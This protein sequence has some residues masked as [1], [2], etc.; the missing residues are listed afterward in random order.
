MCKWK[1]QNVSL[2]LLGVP[3]T[4]TLHDSLLL[5]LKLKLKHNI[6]QDCLTKFL[7]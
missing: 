1:N 7:K 5:L 3:V 2:R 4:V 6:L